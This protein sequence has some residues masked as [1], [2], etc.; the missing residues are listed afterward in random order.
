MSNPLHAPIPI[1]PE[2]QRLLL[3]IIEYSPDFIA[4]ARRD[5]RMLFV[6]RAGQEM[7]GLDG[8]E[9]VGRTSIADYVS[10]EERERFRREVMPSLRNTGQFRGELRLRHFKTGQIVLVEMNSF[11][12]PDPE[13]GEA[14]YFACVARD[15]T[16]RRRT[17]A[18]LRQ[19]AYLLRTVTDATPDSV[20]VKD[21]KGRY[22]MVNEAGAHSVGY[23]PEGLLG[24]D[25]T[26]LFGAEEARSLREWDQ[27][28]MESG[29][30]LTR[31]E[32]LTLGGASYC[33]TSTKVPYRDEQGN[34]IGLIGVSRD[35]TEQTRAEAALRMSEERFRAFMDHSPA[36]AW[37]TDGAGRMLYASDPYHRQIQLPPGEVVGRH[38][39]ELFPPEV[40]AVYLENI[41]EVARTGQTLKVTEPALRSDGSKGELLVYKF[42]L[43][44]PGGDVAIGG[45][46]VDVTD[47]KRAE[48]G[49]RLRD[50]A[51]RA[52]AGGITIT[53]PTQPDNPVV[54]VNQGFERLT[55]YTQEEIV[56]SNC[57]LLQG[58]A[59]DPATV[60]ELR[61]AA[62]EGRSAAV[63]ILNYRKDG[64]A[65]WNALSISP[66]RDEAG[67][68]THWVG[69]QTDVTER[70]QLEE[71]F[72][73][74]QKMEA[75]GRLAG[76]VAH[77]FN[78][79]LTIV[80]GYGLLLLEQLPPQDPARAMVREMI[81]A[82]ERA[83][84]LTRQL[85]A[86]SRKAMV[87]L[88][89]LSLKEVVAD[90]ERLLRRVIGED[91]ELV[92]H[93]E[94][95]V[96]RVRGDAGQ[97]T[98]VL[99]NLAVNARDAMPRGGRLTIEI[100]NVDLGEEYLRTHPEAR[101]GR[102]VLLSV[103]DTGHGIPPEVLPR[104]WEPFFSTKDP[105]KGTGLGLSVVHGIIQQAGGHTTVTSEVGRGTTFKVLLPIVE[106][107]AVSSGP[108]RSRLMPQGTETV[109]LAE[110][111]DGVRTL[112][113]HVLCNCG[114]TV[115][116]A[117]DGEDAL[118][119]ACLHI[120]R[121]DLVVTDVVMPRLGGRELA[122]RMH[123]RDPSVRILYLSGYTDDAVVR[124]GILEGEVA[125]LG[126]P[127]SPSDLAHKVRE[128]LDRRPRGA[129]LPPNDPRRPR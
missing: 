87:E 69:V 85:L 117:R 118:R 106:A 7:L 18:E 88:R 29:Q 61:R 104:I 92:V 115:L 27:K 19:T 1:A 34:V 112:A 22:V 67:Q 84:G 46:S 24:K 63:E 68:I 12:M 38:V 39:S 35:I 120:G 64:T 109:L 83:S 91:I 126:K 97:F 86:F 82:G 10:E 124:H 51:L 89:V 47:L 50:Q 40:A 44:Q 11:A 48:A 111:E 20:F 101:P 127:F 23:T 121:I 70:R 5:E 62:R 31:K 53:D 26:A 42:P 41:H 71:Q 72:R 33:F 49:L 4:I 73:Q 16:E 74:A 45:V 105:S 102:H 13:T 78:N 80:A 93:A 43:P 94:P 75:L 3:S 108:E 54:F 8:D 59:T 17:E 9:A 114:Y 122:E 79:L 95:D 96:G 30:R 66:I 65:F 119:L 98:Q 58:P 14:S 107:R 60:A 15:V 52:V 76:G 128:V 113:R 99:L 103:S 110:D 6:N 21:R 81:D 57:R 55:G 25:D 2:S 116:E 125:F 32:S 77:D 123:E 36:I 90:T 37:I 100:R 56:G 28:V 129:P